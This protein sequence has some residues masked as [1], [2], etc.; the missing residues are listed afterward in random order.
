MTSCAMLAGM[1]PMAFG[2]GEAGH[3]SA[4]VGHL[5][6]IALRT[7]LSLKWD[8]VAE[9]FVGPNAADAN[10]HVAREMRKP[11]DYSFGA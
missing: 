9:T 7:G 8:P 11:Y 4:V 10:K 2:M 6:V 3:Q 5:I 1:A